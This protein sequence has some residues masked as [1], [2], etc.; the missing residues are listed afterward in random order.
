MHPTLHQVNARRVISVG[1]MAVVL[2]A[3]S[4]TASS[5]AA[6]TGASAGATGAASSAA[7][8]T[9]ATGSDLAIDLS[10][11]TLNVATYPVAIGSDET[12]LK[13]A[14]LLD[15]PY[16][17]SSR[18]IPDTGTQTSAVLQ[19]TAD[20]SRGS[21]VANAL[22]IGGASTTPNFLSVAT[23]KIS[24]ATQWT[25]AKPDITSVAQLKGKKV[26]YTPQQHRPVLPPPAAGER[27][28]HV[29]GHRRSA[30]VPCEWA[31]GAARRQ[32]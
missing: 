1:L 12:L 8:S 3:C 15:T 6:T 23:L 18:P 25:V 22:L 29:Q 27:R 20:I 10:G 28:A 2:G 13:A 19:G 21:G 7:G 9:A 31:G 4:A 14:G 32:R 16:K 17:V 5:P 26:A 24:T 11:V 30:S